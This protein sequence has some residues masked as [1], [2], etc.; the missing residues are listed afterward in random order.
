MFLSVANDIDA[1]TGFTSLKIQ[2]IIFVEFDRI[3]NRIIVHTLD[4]KFYTMGTLK[5]LM[6]GL[7]ASGFEFHLVDRHIGVNVPKVTYLDVGDRAAYFGDGLKSKRAL[8]ANKNI[9]MFKK[10]IKGTNSHTVFI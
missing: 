9:D 4:D 5:F 7:N 10:I 8:I 6:D 2:D 3:D 1:Q